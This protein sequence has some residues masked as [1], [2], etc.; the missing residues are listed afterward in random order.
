[1]VVCTRE[2]ECGKKRL[3]HRAGWNRELFTE[4]KVVEVMLFKGEHKVSLFFNG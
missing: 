4:R 3:C 2:L 1:M